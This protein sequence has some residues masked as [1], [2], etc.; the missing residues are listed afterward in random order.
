M[1]RLSKSV[2]RLAE[3]LKGAAAEMGEDPSKDMVEKLDVLIKQNEDIAKALLLLLEINREHLPNISKHVERT[4]NAS[5]APRRPPIFQAAHRR[6]PGMNMGPPP[7]S[8]EDAF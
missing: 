2:D 3:L 1:A 6:L 5:A 7:K 8:D 4:A